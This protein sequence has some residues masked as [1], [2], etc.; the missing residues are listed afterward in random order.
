MS[1]E[2]VTDMLK[3]LFGALDELACQHGIEKVDM[4]GD[5]YIATCNFIESHGTSVACLLTAYGNTDEPRLAET[6]H[7]LRVAR[8]AVAAMA[9]G[10][11]TL[12]DVDVS[13]ICC[14][15]D[16]RSKPDP[17]HRTRVW[18]G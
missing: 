13:H 14:T 17:Q 16:A 2:K 9:A 7:A 15:V 4:I 10:R 8:F 5:A 6:D 11:A 1:A 18:G 12:I 3:R